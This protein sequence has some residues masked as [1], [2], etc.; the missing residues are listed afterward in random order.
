MKKKKKKIKSN[1]LQVSQK[2]QN[3]EEKTPKATK[4]RR[5]NTKSNTWI[6]RIKPM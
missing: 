4:P 6:T 3:P 2:Q 5:E 1:P